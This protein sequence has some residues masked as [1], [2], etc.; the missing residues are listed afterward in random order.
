MREALERDPRAIEK[1]FLQ[2]ELRGLGDLRRLARDA[3]IP[4]ATVPLARLRRL[5]GGLLHQGVL[6]QRASLRYADLEELLQ[7][8]APNV[9]AVRLRKPRLLVLDGIEDPRNF[10]AVIR[11]AVAA[12]VKGILV[13]S[14]RMAPL[15]AAVIKASA[16]T[17]L[18]VAIARTDK[19]PRVLYQLKERGFFV[20]GTAASGE[21]SLWDADWDRPIALVLG[22]ESTGMRPVVAKECDDR[23]SIPMPGDVESLNVSVAAG[24]L[25]FAAARPV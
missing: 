14:K 19:L 10:G 13:T 15:S 5:A 18:R 1:L 8:M 12:G 11:T 3:D 25:L 16:G 20:V 24:I 6:A 23:V 4:V 7:D 2:Q 17:A 9:D 21:T 22:S